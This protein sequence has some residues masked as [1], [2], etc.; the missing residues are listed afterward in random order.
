MFANL[1]DEELI[2]DEHYR[3][4]LLSHNTK[5]FGLHREKAPVSISLP[6]EPIQKSTT[7]ANDSEDDVVTPK[8]S[9]VNGVARPSTTPG[10]S[11]AA[12]PN[13]ANNA[14]ANANSQ[15][16]HL[17]STTEERNSL[18]KHTTQNSHARLSTDKPTDLFSTSAKPKTSSEA[19]TSEAANSTGLETTQAPAEGE[20][21]EK[22]KEG[23][24]L[25]GKKFR[26]NFPKKLGRNSTDTKPA[27]VD[28]KA[29]ESDKSDDKDDKSVQDNFF[30]VIQKIR[31]EYDEHVHNKPQEP[32]ISGITPSMLNETPML[33]PPFNIT[34]IIN[35]EKPDSGGVADLYRGTVSKLG[36]DA[37]LIE[38][39]APTWLGDLLLHNRLPPKE[40]AKVAFILLPYQDSLPS[41]ASQDGNN[42]L[43]AN[44]M[45]RAKKILAYVAERIE[46]LPAQPEPDALKPEEY[47]ELLCHDQVRRVKVPK[48]VFFFVIPD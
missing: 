27:T 18:E 28:E 7:N 14:T 19:L 33:R 48:R 12:A 36:Q 15:T 16:S 43:N 30:G 47:L 46:T 6:L 29:E 45:L 2:R 8:A 39:T 24:S 37:D 21:D 42:R 32:L 11:I 4:N 44:R 20:K 40:I 23:S 13:P 1:I 17:P 3:K 25:F 9:A 41:I 38:K 22:H 10:L 5:T 31:H 35:E 26:M 34:V